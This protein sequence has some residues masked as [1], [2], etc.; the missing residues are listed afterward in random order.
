MTRRTILIV[1]A[2]AVVATASAARLAAQEPEQKQQQDAAMEAYLKYATPGEYHK[3]LEQFVGTWSTQSKFWTAPGAPP[4]ESTGT[5]EHALVLGGR[6]VKVTY[7]GEMM[8]QT[9]EG[10]GFM[11]YDNYKQA[12][13]DFWIDNFGTL[14]LTSEGQC[15]DTG[16]VITM[17]G[18]FDDPVTS[19]TVSYRTVYTFAD[20]DHY[21]LEM[22]NQTPDG[23]EF[24]SLE[25][26][27][28]R[29]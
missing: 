19:Q 3:Y 23:Q 14:M 22:F 9:F 18:S 24:K 28:T 17:N 12:F 20:P 7:R 15:D 25:I 2:L 4:Q 6:F 29:R 1:L 27:H 8:G 5:A 13:V 26:L 16:K 10:M 11:G 21:T